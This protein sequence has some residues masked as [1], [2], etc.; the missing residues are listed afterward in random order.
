MKHFTFIKKSLLV[1]AALLTWG[2]QSAFADELQLANLKE[3]GEQD[4]EY[5]KGVGDQ[6]LS[7][8]TVDLDNVATLTGVAKSDLKLY[9]TASEG[10]LTN[11]T[12]ANNGGYWLAKDGTRTDW[13]TAFLCV[14][15]DNYMD[16]S[17]FHVGQ[18]DKSNTAGDVIKAS[19]YLVGGTNYYKLNV[20][21]NVVGLTGPKLSDLTSVGEQTSK[22]DVLEGDGVIKTFTIDIDDVA[23]KL[24]VDKSAIT[25]Y[26]NIGNGMISDKATGNAGGFWL[27]K[28]GLRANWGSA[29][30]N[31]E[32]VADKDFGTINVSQYDKKNTAGE[33]I[34]A[35]LYLVG[36][37]NYYA[38]NIE[39][40]VT[41]APAIDDITKYTLTGEKNLTIK[42]DP[43]AWAASQLST[44]ITETGLKYYG[45]DENGK[46][47]QNATD[48]WFSKDGKMRLCNENNN[49]TLYVQAIDRASNFTTLNVGQF[50]N[51]FQF[52]GSQTVTLYLVN[53]E[54]KSY[55][56][57]NVTLNVNAPKQ[58]VTVSD[59][60]YATVVANEALDFSES[61]LKAF[62]VNFDGTSVNYTE[63]TTVPKG[64]AVLVYA[65]EAGDYNVTELA[66]AD[67]V[68][69]SLK[70]ANEAVTADGTQ[71]VL[72]KGEE[73]LGWYEVENGSQIP[74]GKGYLV[75]SATNAKGFYPVLDKTVTAINKVQNAED[76]TN[77]P[78]FNLA[79][80]RVGKSYKG[81]VIKNGKKLIQK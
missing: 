18:Y 39:F 28:D 51:A 26:A 35:T 48:G 25:L 49:S 19:L 78:I 23:S 50:P 1:V 59:A 52:G 55:Y 17:S 41:E 31:V 20:T 73:G 45:Y 70:A 44:G 66:S 64:T 72:A 5:T 75:V 33:T 24:G 68:T 2:G 80:Q 61:G 9:A 11:A 81:V 36:G 34:K 58:T 42:E 40:N 32:P 8:L 4:A 15:P 46:L 7:T 12:S 22:F 38:L 57:V 43:V 47:V 60:K 67:A 37:S 30:L 10:V 54:A 14:E 71:Y 27:D 63:V 62:A 76:N 53:L 6:S 79:G 77:A 65:E 56:K 3:V 13:V 29:F 69:T 16:F 74:A 21:F